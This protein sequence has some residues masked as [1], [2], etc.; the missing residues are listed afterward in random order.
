MVLFIEGTAKKCR[1][2]P[3]SRKQISGCM[4]AGFGGMGRGRKARSQKHMKKFLGVVVDVFV[5]FQ[6]TFIIVL[7]SGTEYNGS[8]Y[9]YIAK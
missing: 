9:V 8:I 7:V 4:K 3:S 1:L 6:L 2:I 5:I